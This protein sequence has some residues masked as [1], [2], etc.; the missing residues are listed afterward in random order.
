M[1]S[2]PRRGLRGL[3]I[4][5]V[6]LACLAFIADR[7]AE[8]AAENKLATVAADEAARYDVRADKT[9]VEIGGFGFL[10]QLVKGSFETI[11][12]TMDKPTI[13]KVPAEDLTVT[14]HKVDVP[15]ELITGDG[16]AKALVNNA[17]LRAR[18]S[19]GSLTKLAQQTS[20]LDTLTLRTTQGKLQA[21]LKFRGVEIT[22][23]VK[24]Q[25]RDDAISLTASELP[26][27]LPAP[28]KNSLNTLLEKGFQVPQLPFDAKLK[29]ITVENGSIALLATATDVELGRA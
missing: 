7:V 25:I 26:D 2:R 11:T 29:Q 10:P 6:L 5:I 18:L 23:A 15:R 17:D 22:A 14:M 28:V 21:I 12:V 19:A 9:S 4:A 27:D 8:A 1:S 16:S 3:V 20:G 13:S 24:P